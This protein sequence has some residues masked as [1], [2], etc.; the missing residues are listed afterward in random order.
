MSKIEN[1]VKKGR[2]GESL[3]SAYL[4]MKG[5]RILKRNYVSPG[6]ELD[7]IA[8]EPQQK[9]LVCV[10]VKRWLRP[11]YPIDDI[12]YA[13]PSAKMR[14]LRK[15]LSHFIATHMHLQYDAI[16]IDVILLYEEQVI[17]IEGDW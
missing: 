10:E 6:S 14:R 8:Y 1:T 16:R 17:H 12:R 11:Y 5:Y 2:A 4:T 7:I 9:T 3:A 15:G 13:V